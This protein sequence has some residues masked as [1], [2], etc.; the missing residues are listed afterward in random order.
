V[1]DVGFL[2]VWMFMCVAFAAYGYYALQAPREETARFKKLGAAMFGEKISGFV[3]KE[4]GLR[5]AARAFVIGGLTFFAIGAA[6]LVVTLLR[7]S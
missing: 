6:L 4:E 7:G 2:L 1:I 3:Y 5:I